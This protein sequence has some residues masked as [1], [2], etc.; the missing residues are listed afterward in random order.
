[1]ASSF[2]LL[3]KLVYGAILFHIGLAAPTP[4]HSG[5]E[6]YVSLSGD[7]ANAGTAA[8]PFATAQRAQTA[9]RANR[10]GGTAYFDAGVYQLNETLVLDR[11]DN[12]CTYAT[13]PV[14]AA[15]GTQAVLSGGV[16]IHDWTKADLKKATALIP[17][18]VRNQKFSQLWVQGARATRARSPNIV[19]GDSYARGYSTNST[20]QYKASINAA[21]FVYQ[22][23]DIKAGWAGTNATVLVFAAWTATWY[24]IES[25]DAASSTVHF[26]GTK[27]VDHF[28]DTAGGKRFVVE[29]LEE[30]LDAEV[31]RVYRG[32]IEYTEAL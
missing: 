24:E 25:V 30:L 19:A 31:S 15:K 23:S 21:G 1:M 22:G 11:A 14:D 8:D 3:C 16:A 7:D 17:K 9:L 4:F 32:I 18:E 5:F 6:V 27:A 28:S 13:N 12:G 20:H 10:G 2:S 26:K 29:N